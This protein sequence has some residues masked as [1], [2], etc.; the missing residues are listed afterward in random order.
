MIKTVSLLIL[1]CICLLTSG[2]QPFVLEVNFERAKTVDTVVLKIKTPGFVEVLTAVK[3][4]KSISIEG[5]LKD[6]YG[7]GLLTTDGGND[8]LFGEFIELRP[9][10]NVIRLFNDPIQQDLRIDTSAWSPSMKAFNSY[11]RAIEPATDSLTKNWK[12]LTLLKI[13]HSPDSLRQL[14]DSII[15]AWRRKL[16]EAKTLFFRQHTDQYSALHLF[17][18]HL[19]ADNYARKKLGIDSLH[20]IFLQFSPSL[21][22]TELGNYILLELQQLLAVGL[23]NRAP[24]FK[25]TTSDGTPFQ[26]SEAKGSVVLLCFWDANCRSCIASFPILK[27]I[28][29]QYGREELRMISVSIDARENTWQKALQQYQLTWPQALDFAKF[30][31]KTGTSDQSLRQLYGV[32]YIPQYFL[33]SKKGMIVY[34]SEL[35]QDDETYS[36]LQAS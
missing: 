17:D 29:K 23:E 34:H 32:E 18:L 19:L 28:A 27:N 15:L 9:G 2:Q 22:Q 14:Q 13:K 24:D 30:R 26:L 20:R 36:I 21:R 33:I 6:P 10:Q 11:Q 7:I 5:L 31:M 35:S 1:L 12:Q 8:S 25:I 16:L 3:K 4:D